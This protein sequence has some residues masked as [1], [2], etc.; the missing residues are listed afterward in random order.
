MSLFIATKRTC[1]RAPGGPGGVI[2]SSQFALSVTELE[3]AARYAAERFLGS[4]REDLTVA[5]GW[6]SL[7]EEAEAATV[8]R[9]ADAVLNDNEI[10]QMEA[11]LRAP[12]KQDR[13][14]KFSCI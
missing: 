13:A 10:E 5:S 14:R 1:H 9:A 3:R 8:V 4:L 6:Q 2:R 11:A 7:A 12:P